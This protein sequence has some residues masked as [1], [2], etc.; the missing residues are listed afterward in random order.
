MKILDCERDVP[1]RT[2]S[3]LM[4]E[5]EA[6]GLMGTLTW[7]FGH[8][9]HMAAALSDEFDEDGCMVLMRLHQQED[10]RLPERYR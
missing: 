4:T 8:P 2:A 1:V 5:R 9:G 6:R 10:N 7:M 3:V